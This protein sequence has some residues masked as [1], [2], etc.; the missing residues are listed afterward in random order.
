MGKAF[1][2]GTQTFDCGI[3]FI[4]KVALDELDGQA[5]FAYATSADHDQL[6][7]SQKLCQDGVS[8]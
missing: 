8:K 2:R 7:F 5:G 4:H 6:V 3:V 1:N